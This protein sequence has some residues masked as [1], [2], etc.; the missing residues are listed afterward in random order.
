[1]DRGV[2]MVSINGGLLM[3]PPHLTIKNPY[4]KGAAE[5]YEDG[6]FVTV[7]LNFIVDSHICIFEKV[8]SYGRYLCFNH[9]ISC[10]KDATKLAPIL[11][12]ASEACSPERHVFLSIFLLEELYLPQC[13]LVI[14]PNHIHVPESERTKL[15]FGSF[16]ADYFSDYKLCQW[17]Y[18]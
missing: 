12:L 4:L 15:S 17:S 7:V 14:L 8:S 16:G 2:N 3:A 13:Q 9:V 5:M 18:E 6:V 1:M 11:F 10:N